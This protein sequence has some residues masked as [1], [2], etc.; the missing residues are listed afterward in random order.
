MSDAP[1]DP[2]EVVREAFG[3]R[4]WKGLDS[5]Q[6]CRVCED[7]H[8][9]HDPDCPVP[10]ARE[11]LD[12]AEWY[13]DRLEA[14]LE[15]ELEEVERLN[16]ALSKTHIA[17]GG[18]GEWVAKPGSKL[19]AGETGDLSVDVPALAAKARA[20]AFREAA[21][22]YLV[23]IDE[24]NIEATEYDREFVRGR[25]YGINEYRAAIRARAEELSA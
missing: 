18:D 23:S 5:I 3:P 4:A 24:R 11:A 7:E 6:V 17:L 10:A 12:S 9:S 21:E 13:R 16:D 25:A 19:P 14:S 8:P 15:H 20:Q 2:F 22:I 1:R